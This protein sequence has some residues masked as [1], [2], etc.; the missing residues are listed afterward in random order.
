[1]KH[2]RRGQRAKG[3]L[4]KRTENGLIVFITMKTASCLNSCLLLDRIVEWIM[5]QNSG[6]ARLLGGFSSVL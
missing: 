6:K 2:P 3:S 5:L 1:M 4:Y